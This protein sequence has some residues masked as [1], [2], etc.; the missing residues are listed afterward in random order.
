[1]DHGPENAPTTA[2]TLAAIRM[3]TFAVVATPRDFP[4]IQTCINDLRYT[5]RRCILYVR[6]PMSLHVLV[7]EDDSQLHTLL[8]VLLSR[9]GYEVDFACDGHNGLE[10]VR[11]A[12]Y[13]AILLDLL[14]PNATGL[15]LLDAIR[16]WQPSMVEKV[17]IISGAQES[18]LA[19]ARRY[20]VHAV[21]RKPFDIHELVREVNT[22]S[23]KIC[24]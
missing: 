16:K 4:Q 13:D 5:K 10:K 22:C 18:V 1:M 11:D 8:Y 14:L 2:F 7:V 17:I 6:P 15:Q 3:H 21:L 9:A 24:M 20:P 23:K 19:R 12:G